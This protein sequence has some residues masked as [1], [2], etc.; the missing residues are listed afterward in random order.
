LLYLLHGAL[1][2]LAFAMFL[3]AA[4]QVIDPGGGV[5]GPPR[6]EVTAAKRWA[7][8]LVFAAFGVLS[9]WGAV[10][11]K[12]CLNRINPLYPEMQI[13]L[14]RS[15]IPAERSP[16]AGLPQTADPMYDRDLDRDV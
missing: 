1:I 9:A 5:F 14:H 2:G 7:V 15:G 12:R 11:L 4:I 3:G 16:Q 10:K 13:G 8:G 6:L